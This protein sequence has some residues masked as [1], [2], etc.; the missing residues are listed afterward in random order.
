ME[1]K[2][3]REEVVRLRG[4]FLE[5]SFCFSTPEFEQRLEELSRSIC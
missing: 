1:G 3:V 5:L 2:E 4:R